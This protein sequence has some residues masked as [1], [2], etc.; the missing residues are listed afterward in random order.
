MD[1]ED[2]NRIWKAIKDLQNRVDEL[3]DRVKR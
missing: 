2:W 3:E 1:D